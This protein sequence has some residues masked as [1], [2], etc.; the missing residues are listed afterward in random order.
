MKKIG[1]PGWRPT[2][3]H[4]LAALFPMMRDDELD[5]LADDI[6]ANGLLHPV[7]IDDQGVLIDGRNRLNACDRAKVEP[8]YERTNGH[9]VAALIVSAN[10]S[11]RNLNNGQ[12]ATLLAMI[13]PAG[14]KG[15][16]GK[17]DPAI[18]PEDSSGFIR[19]VQQARQ[20]LRHSEAMAVSVKDGTM[21]FDTALK[22]ARNGEEEGKSR[23]ARMARLRAG[24]P[25]V[26][27]LVEDERLTLEAGLEEL[28]QRERATRQVVSGAE[29]SIDS[30]MTIKPHVLVVRSLAALKPTDLALINLTEDDRKTVL[31]KLDI[32]ALKAA[33]RDLEQIK[34]G[35][36]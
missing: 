22:Q 15:G 9:D 11:R 20:I 7:L 6:K 18:N 29:D 16:R 14:G 19:M 3:V 10:I 23:E 34:R 28:A 17:K 33:V 24:A 13:Y 21:P 35:R 1:E 32:D 2:E 27:A 25:D 30:L 5:D 31:E 36:Y 12:R 26:A 4:P 8:R